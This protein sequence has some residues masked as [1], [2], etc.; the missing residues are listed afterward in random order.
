[1]SLRVEWRLSRTNRDEGGEVGN[2]VTI[3]V[4][5]MSVQRSKAQHVP[6]FDSVEKST[7]LFK[8]ENTTIEVKRIRDLWRSKDKTREE[9]T[10]MK[11]RIL[12]S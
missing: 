9:K 7:G 5:L 3:L 11:K 12:W 10:W 4:L 1:M 6:T 8:R 2:V